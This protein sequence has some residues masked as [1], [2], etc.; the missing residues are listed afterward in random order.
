MIELGDRHIGAITTAGDGWYKVSCI[1][2]ADQL[3]QFIEVRDHITEALGREHPN[4]TVANGLVLMLL[5]IEY[6]AG[7]QMQVEVARQVARMLHNAYEL[8]KQKEA[9]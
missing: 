8:E 6:G 9:A 5:C 7:I 3:Q 2:H 1:I 4:A